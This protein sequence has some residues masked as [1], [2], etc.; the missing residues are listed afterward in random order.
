M[1]NEG[2]ETHL[3]IGNHSREIKIAGEPIVLY[4]CP[5]CSRDFAREPG[6]SNWRAIRVSTFSIMFLAGAITEEWIE[7]PCP[8]STPPLVEK[9]EPAIEV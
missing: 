7:E 2:L 5:L 8:G 1:E 3:W 4:R 9:L 6:R